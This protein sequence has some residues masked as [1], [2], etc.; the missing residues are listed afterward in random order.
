MQKI[1]NIPFVKAIVYGNVFVALGA[2]AQVFVTYLVFHIPLNYNNKSYL[3]FVLLSTYLQYNM[4]RGIMLM[5]YHVLSERSNWLRHHKKT[6]LISIGICLVVILFLCNTLS[7]TSIGIMVGAEVLSTLYYM[8]PFNLRRYG[9][10]KPFLISL[11]WVISCVTVPLI[12]NHLLTLNSCWFM[13]SQFLFIATLCILFDIKDAD[14]DYVTGVNTYANKFG[15][16]IT[17][18]LA[19][20]LM[21]G[22]CLCY[23]FFNQVNQHVALTS[24]IIGLITI[25]SIF[26]TTD[27][28]HSFYYYLWLDGLLIV[29][30]I[31][32]LLFN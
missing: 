9:Y 30:A 14:D 22:S 23:L 21:M 3:L 27:K 26:F 28:R 19:I 31:L 29:Q 8:Q 4:Q 16:K 10:V 11:I 18:I 20:I 15:A 6:L 1:V 5:Q 13:S 12:E 25:V 2:L 24:I 32:L 17:K 7:Y